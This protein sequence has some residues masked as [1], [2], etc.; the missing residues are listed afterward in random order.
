MFAFKNIKEKSEASNKDKEL[1]FEVMDRMIAGD[2]STVSAEGFEDPLYAKKLNEIVHS[3]KVANNNYVMRLNETMESI[4]DNSFAKNTLDQIDIQKQGVTE[5][6]ASGENL[7]QCIGKVTRHMGEIS[8]STKDM[9]D[10]SKKSSSNMNESIRVVNESADMISSINSQ[11]KEFQDRVEKIG[12]I[13]DMV[14]EVASQS[15]LL[16]LNAS[17]EAA[18]AGEAGKGFAVVADQVRELSSNTAESAETIVQ[19]VNE[20]KRDMDTL[21]V[22]VDETTAKLNEGNS[23][24]EGSLKDIEK[25]N[26]QMVTISSIVESTLTELGIQNEIADDFINKVENISQAYD[27][28]HEECMEFGTHIYKIGRYVDQCRS[29][30]FRYA[31]SVTLQDNLRIFEIDHFIF[32]WRVYNNAVGFETLRIDQV[33]NPDGCKLGKWINA[34]KEEK[35]SI[36]N[37]TE[38][39]DVEQAHRLL[40]KYAVESWSAKQEGDVQTAIDMFGNCLTTFTTFKESINKLKDAYRSK[41]ETEE[42]EIVIF[43]R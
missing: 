17:I 41:G 43:N 27:K 10:I 39:K 21:A 15:N 22:S 32:T 36:V 29:D 11:V 37:T 20:L 4:S 18:R 19:Y 30:M 2:F 9:L 13:V 6:S 3:F 33:N 23:K 42:T 1:L 12:Q 40:H 38:F 31:G 25:M 28:I 34:K 16:A 5:M 35:D 24:V 14:K 26:T 8:D 7:G